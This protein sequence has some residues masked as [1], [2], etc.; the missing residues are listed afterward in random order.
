MR[1]T[2]NLSTLSCAKRLKT[3]VILLP[4][5]PVIHSHTNTH[6]QRGAGGE[7]G[8]EGERDGGC[9]RDHEIRYTST[10][11]GLGEARACDVCDVTGPYPARARNEATEN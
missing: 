11:I 1:C 4:F 5:V 9:A 10:D 8:R 3:I 2:V 6:A 7:G